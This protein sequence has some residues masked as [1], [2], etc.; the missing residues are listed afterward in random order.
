MKITRRSLRH[1]IVESINNNTSETIQINIDDFPLNVELANTELLRQKGL[2]HRFHLRQDDGMLFIH[3]T[4]DM[5]G[6]YMKN[7][8]VPLSIAYADEDGFIFQIENMNPG[9]LNSVMSIQPAL[10][11]LEMN[12]GWFDKNKIGL[13][14]KIDLYDGNNTD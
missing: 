9:D 3:D 14:S 11:A 2:M 12:Q 1:L 7:T 6:Y 4:P 13:G 8:H 10:Y 5:C